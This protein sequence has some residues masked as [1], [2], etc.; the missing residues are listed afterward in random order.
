[1]SKDKSPL[2]VNRPKFFYGYVI[3]AAALLMA[4][5]MWGARFS[6]AVFFSPVLEEFGWSRAATSGGF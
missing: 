5:A 3:V 4:V 6:F 2:T 1:L